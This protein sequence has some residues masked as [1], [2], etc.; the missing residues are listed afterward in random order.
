MALIF[1]ISLALLTI[2]FLVM[3]FILHRGRNVIDR[4]STGVT[5]WYKTSDEYVLINTEYLKE[6]WL[7]RP[8]LIGKKIYYFYIKVG[9]KYDTIHTDNDTI[10][11]HKGCY[12]VYNHT[13]V[14]R[15][16]SRIKEKTFMSCPIHVDVRE[17]LN[18]TPSIKL[19]ENK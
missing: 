4:C 15:L 14:D 1:S 10:S 6:E 7:D 12:K 2:I 16:L 11:I 19:E 17:S 3:F 9:G 8:S 13:W 5:Y 18:Y